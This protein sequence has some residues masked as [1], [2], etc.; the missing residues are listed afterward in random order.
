MLMH[1]IPRLAN[2]DKEAYNNCRTMLNVL[3]DASAYFHTPL[4]LHRRGRLLF[5]IFHLGSSPD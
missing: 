2:D 3:Q 1:E 4:T 5:L